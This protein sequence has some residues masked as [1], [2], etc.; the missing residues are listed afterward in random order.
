M[1]LFKSFLMAMLMFS[2]IPMPKN[3]W[4]DKYTNLIILN[5]SIVG[6]I[7]GT[8]WFGLAFVLIG[9][10]IPVLIL[11]VFILLI[12]FLL[13]GFLH[14]DGFMDTAD[15]ILSRR[16]LEEKRRILKDPQVGAFAVIALMC[17]ML[18]QFSAIHTILI[19]QKPLFIFIFT[20]IVSRAIAGL[21]LLNLKPISE[22]GYM[23][24]FKLGTN[25]YHTFFTICML[26][27]SLVVAFVIGGISLLIPLAIGAI[28]SVCIIAYVYRQLEG[29][30]GDLCGYII[31]VI[32]LVILLSFAIL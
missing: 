9:M 7:I 15:A 29:L 27:G 14:V 12:P 5:I 30:S 11:S 23:A 1:K 21:A 26:I 32:E 19:R 20:P 2:I 28:G 18:L 13:S 17:L 31:V 4:D 24:T 8:I 25:C 16:S 10:E 22:T 3:S 6:A